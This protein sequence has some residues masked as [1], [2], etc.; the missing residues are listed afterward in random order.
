MTA[1][2]NES[3]P[4]ISGILSALHPAEDPVPALYQEPA[5]QHPE[6]QPQPMPIL[7][8]QEMHSCWNV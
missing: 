7:Q 6:D 2:T 8:T 3:V 1:Y 4:F 5:V